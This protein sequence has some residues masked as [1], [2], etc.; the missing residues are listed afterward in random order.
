M[1]EDPRSFADAQAL[2]DRQ[3][4]ELNKLVYLVLVEIRALLWT[5]RAE[6]ATALAEAFHNLPL[7]LY[8]DQFSFSALAWP[9]SGI[10]KNTVPRP[11]WTTSRKLSA[12]LLGAG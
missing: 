3:R 5:D 12:S 2:D 9:P 1:P 8:S 4:R 7:F 10:S 11:T 6:Q